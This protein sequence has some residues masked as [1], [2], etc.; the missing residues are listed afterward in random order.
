[1]WAI[2]R[3]LREV[4]ETTAEPEAIGG[5]VPGTLHLIAADAE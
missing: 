3:T 2:N 1:M 5:A 4:S